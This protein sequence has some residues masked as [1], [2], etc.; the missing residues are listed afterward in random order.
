[1]GTG[2]A[3]LLRFVLIRLN[4]KNTSHGWLPQLLTPWLSTTRHPMP[5]HSP[6]PTP[7]ENGAVHLQVGTFRSNAS[8]FR[9]SH[10]CSSLDGM[11]EVM[12]G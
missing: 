11:W 4:H 3:Q 10:R 1:M 9:E 12:S 7:P 2:E 8:T 6:F 5:A